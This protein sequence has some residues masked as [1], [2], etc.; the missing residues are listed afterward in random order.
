MGFLRDCIRVANLCNYKH[1][2]VFVISPE[3]G[4]IS[5]DACRKKGDKSIL[6]YICILLGYKRQFMK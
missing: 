6:K 2:I 3:D 5:A 4:A 1:N